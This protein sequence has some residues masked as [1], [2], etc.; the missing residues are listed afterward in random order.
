M[1]SFWKELFVVFSEMEYF[2]LKIVVLNFK[3]GSGSIWLLHIRSQ[4]LIVNNQLIDSLLKSLTAILEFVSS[5]R[6]IFQVF[7]CGFKPINF[8]H[9]VNIQILSIIVN[10]LISHWTS[11]LHS[12]LSSWWRILDCTLSDMGLVWA[13]YKSFNKSCTFIHRDHSIPVVVEFRKKPVELCPRSFRSALT[14][15]HII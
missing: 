3:F 9:S 12:L 13:L 2:I 6:L 11:I 8:I 10:E 7:A 1:I 14:K 4:K 15:K 5:F